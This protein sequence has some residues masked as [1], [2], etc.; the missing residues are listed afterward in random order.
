MKNLAIALL[1][2]SSACVAEDP[3][4]GF[5]DI[6]QGLDSYN[7]VSLNGVSLNGVSLNGVS[8]NGVSLNGVSINGTSLT[9]VTMTAST[10]TTTT[11]PL[12]GTAIVGSTWTGTTTST[13]VPTI[14][15]R[16]DSALQGTGTNADLWF[17]GISYQTSTGWSPLCGLDGTGAPLMA[18]SVAGQWK[19]STID[20]ARY[21]ASTTYFTVACRTKTVAK[22]VEMG[23]KTF[24]GRTDQLTSCVRLL[25]GD[26]CG[27][28]KAYTLDGTLLNLYDNV[29]IQADTEAW[30]PEAEWTPTGARCINTN[31]SQRFDLILQK[32]PNCIRAKT[33]TCGTTFAQGAVLIDELSP[34]AILAIQTAQTAY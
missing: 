3:A 9:G 20:S 14:K 10:T 26:F 12:S 19:S 24:K 15:L 1:A 16:I 8:L 4:D 30:T 17:Y 33:S 34:S 2:L 18:T 25:R 6:E 27:N 7:G 32:D 21:A 13:T 5:G 31:K 23:Y 29:G 11:T 28:G 22:C